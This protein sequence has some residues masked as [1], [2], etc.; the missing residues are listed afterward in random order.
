MDKE[1]NQPDG[2]PEDENRILKAFLGLQPDQDFS[3][4]ETE[5]NKKATDKTD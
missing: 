4:L 5:E 1:F 3:E 2:T